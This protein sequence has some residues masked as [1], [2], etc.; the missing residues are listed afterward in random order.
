MVR[1]HMTTVTAG[2]VV[3]VPWGLD[4]LEGNVLRVYDT[5]AGPRAVVSVRIPGTDVGEGEDVTLTLPADSL[6]PMEASPNR[7]QPGSWVT[8]RA[9][10]RSVAE[11]IQRATEKLG[12]ITE[13]SEA[14][15]DTGIDLVIHSG[16]SIIVAEVKYVSPRLRISAKEIDR[17]LSLADSTSA[18]FLLVTNASLA[19]S[20]VN[21]WHDGSVPDK[22]Y[23]IK[24]RGPE[25]DTNMETELRLLLSKLRDT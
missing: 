7:S 8:A 13:V 12:E 15:T 2:Q 14:T 1:S 5:G 16:E 4:L 10:E 3:S 11:A 9:Y 24:W 23:C 19:P 22:F 6:E 18:P 25:D 21:R 17:A 20:A